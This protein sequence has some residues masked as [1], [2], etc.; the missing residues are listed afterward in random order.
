[1]NYLGKQ[2]QL[3]MLCSSAWNKVLNLTIRR[4]NLT[5][6]IFKSW[7]LKRLRKATWHFAYVHLETCP[8]SLTPPP[9]WQTVLG[10]LRPIENKTMQIFWKHHRLTPQFPEK[11]ECL[12]PS[13]NQVQNSGQI[14]F[15]YNVSKSIACLKNWCCLFHLF[16]RDILSTWKMTHLGWCILLYCNVYCYIG[17]W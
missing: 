3:T 17:K 13:T 7:N 5:I 1:M 10:I 9:C 4:W 8:V 12:S 16:L 14:C 6:K 15:F 2:W 11:E